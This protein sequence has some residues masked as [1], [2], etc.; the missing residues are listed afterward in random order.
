MEL[1]KKDIFFVYKMNVNLLW[2]LYIYFGRRGIYLDFVFFK[3]KAI[4]TNKIDKFMPLAINK[5]KE[6]Q[7][8][9]A[10]PDD[11]NNVTMRETGKY[12]TKSEQKKLLF[13]TLFQTN[14]FS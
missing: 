1:K 8:H 11:W 3:P 12:K 7:F 14:K 2:G 4:R 10:L 6:A 5:Q 9:V 13:L